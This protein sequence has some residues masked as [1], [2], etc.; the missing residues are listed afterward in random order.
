MATR[1]QLALLYDGEAY[2][3]GQCLLS[4]KLRRTLKNASGGCKIR[5]IAM[6][7]TVLL[8]RMG[9]CLRRAVIQHSFGNYASRSYIASGHFDRESIV[10]NHHKSSHRSYNTARGF[11]SAAIRKAI[12]SEN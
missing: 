7:T 1:A 12:E 8:S 4:R 3:D 10:S 6:M 11:D 9:F 5:P 2:S